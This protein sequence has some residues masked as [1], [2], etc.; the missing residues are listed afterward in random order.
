MTT[1]AVVRQTVVAM[2]RLRT[3]MPSTF[4][5]GCH[6][7]IIS[8]LLCEVMEEMG[9][10][11]K[12]IGLVSAGCYVMMPFFIDIDWVSALHGRAPAVATGVKRTRPDA[13]VLS[14]QGD[15]DLGA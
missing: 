9:I 1:A 12:T 10:A 6:Y 8:R 3:A 11:G 15:G 4:C 2:P 7:G 5:P 13:V 14:L